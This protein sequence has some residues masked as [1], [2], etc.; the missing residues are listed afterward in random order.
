VEL[1]VFQAKVRL[2][3]QGKE[4]PIAECYKG[5]NTREGQIEKVSINNK[6]QNGNRAIRKDQSIVIKID[7]IGI[8]VAK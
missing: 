5:S 2:E 3:E 1:L 8:R 7:G 4:H 6:H